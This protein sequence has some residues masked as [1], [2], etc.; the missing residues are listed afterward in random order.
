MF[1]V[2]VISS[3]DVSR[4][5]GVE[6][7]N[8]QGNLT[9]YADIA[10]LDAVVDLFDAE[11]SEILDAICEINDEP[12]P[13][14]DRFRASVLNSA[15]SAGDVIKIDLE[16]AAAE[17]SQEQAPVQNGTQ[18]VVTVYGSAGLSQAEVRIINGQTTVY[19]AIHNNCVR[20]RC[21]MSDDQISSSNVN[22]NDVPVAA[23]DLR[24]HV[25][26]NGDSIVLYP[27]KAHT[28]GIR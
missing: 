20:E 18:G 26:N 6:S 13:E 27:N 17:A 10:A 16:V 4:T 12:L 14:S 21:R 11:P 19:D 9:S 23:N 8:A 15:P 2:T 28:N 22:V 24:S 3:N 5:V 1:T 25:L 7:N